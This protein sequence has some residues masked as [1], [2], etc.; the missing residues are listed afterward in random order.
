MAV[1]DK[2]TRRGMPSRTRSLYEALFEVV[3]GK[4][5]RPGRPEGA[6]SGKRFM[7]STTGRDREIAKKARQRAIAIVIHENKERVR[8]LY[9]AEYEALIAA[10]KEQ[11]EE[12]AGG[13]E[14]P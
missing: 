12:E 8:E 11:S 9:D 6:G 1:I 3:P 4:N 13:H 2:K 5:R 7:F 10:Q 14:T